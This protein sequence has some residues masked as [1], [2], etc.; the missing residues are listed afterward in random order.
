MFKRARTSHFTASLAHSWGYYTVL[1]ATSAPLVFAAER[2]Y[3]ITRRQP[4]PPALEPSVL[5]RFA[6][7]RGTPAQVCRALGQSPAGATCTAIWRELWRGFWS[8]ASPR[9][10]HLLTWAM[11]PEG[12]LMIPGEYRRI[13]GAGDLE[14]YARST[15]PGSPPPARQP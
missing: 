4:L 8:E 12:R 15:E 13:F 3:P 6:E 7:L 2:S 9:F 11:P 10:S 14:I 5:D 1:K